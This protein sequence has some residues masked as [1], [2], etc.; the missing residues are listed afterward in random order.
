MSRE[1]RQDSYHQ[2]RSRGRGLEV[3]RETRFSRDGPRRPEERSL[4]SESRQSTESAFTVLKSA[5]ENGETL[6]N[7]PVFLWQK[8]KFVRENRDDVEINLEGTDK[9]L[10]RWNI[11]M[12]NILTQLTTALE[13]WTRAVK[14]I[15]GSYGTGVGSYFRLL[16]TF[17]YFNIFV[18]LL[19]FIFLVLPI[20]TDSSAMAGGGASQCSGSDIFLGTGCFEDTIL[21]Y[22]GTV[23]RSGRVSGYWKDFNVAKGYIYV[24]FIGYA[25]YLLS[26][27]R[28]FVSAY[29][30]SFIDNA[31]MEARK[32]G[33]TVFSVWQMTIEDKDSAKELKNKIQE[34]LH[35]L[36]KFKS[37]NKK[38]SRG[39]VALR[40]IVFLFVLVIMAGI[41][42][43]FWE[44]LKWS[45]KAQ[46]VYTIPLIL[47]FIILLLPWLLRLL[48]KV[49][50]A[51]PLKINS[52]L[53]SGGEVQAAGES[54][55]SDHSNLDTDSLP[56]AA[57][58]VL[59]VPE[60]DGR[61]L[62]DQVRTGDVPTGPLRLP[63]HYP[64]QL[65]HRDSLE[66]GR[67]SRF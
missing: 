34:D 23:Y 8:R 1:R 51:N 36:L 12:R 14:Q 47:S 38:R 5:L 48:N 53:V 27:V 6:S 57:D 26:T 32:F 28:G 33:S 63:R 31:E 43:G 22:G 67:D 21:F 10:S 45:E 35:K 56:P 9:T 62:G 24:T 60:Q 19:T 55:C 58:Q 44:L 50:G 66:P 7:V 65:G 25:V 30:A 37:E 29:K 4:T 59:L 42:Y 2:V 40:L 13:P 52:G 17:L 49:G 11:Q 41:C 20:I 16:R 18:S 39:E 61:L 54:V 64:G 15:E 3:E 46:N